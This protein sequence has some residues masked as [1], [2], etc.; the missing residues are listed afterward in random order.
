MILAMILAMIMGKSWELVF[1]SFSFSSDR[2]L[3]SIELRLKRQ[4]WAYEQLIERKRKCF[5]LKLMLV[6]PTLWLGRLNTIA[7]FSDRM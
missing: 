7:P 6:C 4:C 1:V 3:V 5:F 2:K